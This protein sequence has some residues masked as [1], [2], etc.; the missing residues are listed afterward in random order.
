MPADLSRQFAALRQ[1][2]FSIESLFAA[3]LVLAG[4]LSL[5]ISP[6]S[7]QTTSAITEE[8]SLISDVKLKKGEFIVRGTVSD[9]VNPLADIVIMRMKKRGKKKVK[10]LGE[11]RTAVDGTFSFNIK[12]GEYVMFAHTDYE[13]DL[14]EIVDET[15]EIIVVLRKKEPGI[16]R[17]GRLQTGTSKPFKHFDK[18]NN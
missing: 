1:R 12:K 5:N 4:K 3:S 6:T 2:V 14:V 8:V 13:P 9:G 17:L 15:A 10:M 18:T 11:T 7:A 16:I